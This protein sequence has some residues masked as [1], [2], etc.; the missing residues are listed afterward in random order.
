MDW[1]RLVDDF[2]LLGMFKIISRF[3]KKPIRFLSVL[4]I[5]LRKISL[6]FLPFRWESVLIN[7]HYCCFYVISK[8]VKAIFYLLKILLVTL[9]KNGLIV[10]LVK[11]YGTFKRQRFRVNVY[12]ATV[13]YKITF[14]GLWRIKCVKC[15]YFHLI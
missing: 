2:H 8:K 3:L 13:G 5:I 6:Y 9:Y 14:Y 15:H 11:K 10:A 12:L 1:N 7:C 4:K